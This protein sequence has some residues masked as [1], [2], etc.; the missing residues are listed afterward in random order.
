MLKL[1]EPVTAGNTSVFAGYY[2]TGQSSLLY[3]FVHFLGLDGA[4]NTIR[5]LHIHILYLTSNLE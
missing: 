2:E 3:V 1:A 5:Y 4:Q